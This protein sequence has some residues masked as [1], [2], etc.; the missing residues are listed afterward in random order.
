M[1]QPTET[2]DSYDAI[3]NREDLSDI[4]YNISPMET[5][6]LQAW[7]RGVATATRHDW[8]TDELVAASDSNAVVEGF[9]ATNDN[10]PP[11]GRLN[12]YTQISD[13]VVVIAGTQD[14][15]D[16]AGRRSELAYQL[17][18]R[19][20]ELKRDMEATI[21][22]RKPREDGDG[23]SVPRTLAGYE[24]W[25]FDSP[26][27]NS[28]RATAGTPGAEA[29]NSQGLLDGGRRSLHDRR[30]PVQQAV[31]VGLHG[32]Q[33]PVRQGRG[34]APGVGHRRVRLGLRRPPD[35]SQPLLAGPEPSRLRPALLVGGLPAR[36]PPVAARED[37][38]CGDAP[39]PG[40]VHAPI[41]P[42]EGERNR[43]RPDNELARRPGGLGSRARLAGGIRMRG[44]H[45]YFIFG[46]IDDIAT[47]DEVLLPCPD[48]GKCTK[49]MTALAGT[50]NGDAVITAKANGTAMTGGALTV[51]ASGS[52]VGVGDQAYPTALNEVA[53]DGYFSIATNGGGSTVRALGFCLVIE[54]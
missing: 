41:Q 34:Q 52:G 17:S 39:A 47:A 18:K 8:Q 21:T 32:Q 12:N 26:D 3:G 14:A 46:V 49:V 45:H 38:R 54:R 48:G 20:K 5:P 13:K 30:G 4:I 37:R 28:N 43:R 53:P 36:V 40:G 7:G 29:A 51:E 31:R 50:I 22:S 2:F 15:V 35:R 9:D 27:G 19:A 16:K 42:G 6:C 23:S 33:H 25:M 10:V 24:T 44:L 11:T 1:A